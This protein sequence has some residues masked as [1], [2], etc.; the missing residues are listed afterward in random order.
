MALSCNWGVD[1]AFDTAVMFQAARDYGMAAEELQALKGELVVLLRDLSSTGWTT[2]AGKAFESMVSQDW[3]ANLDK[4]C[5]LLVMLSE[6][7]KKSA[8][9]YDCLVRDH[10]DRLR[11][12]S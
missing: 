1:L 11:L 5:D 10:V 12:G 4:Y 7:L 3:G 8:E 2:K 9:E 6:A